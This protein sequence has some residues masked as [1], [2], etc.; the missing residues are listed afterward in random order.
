MFYQPSVST[1]ITRTTG[2]NGQPIETVEESPYAGASYNKLEPAAPAAIT[3]AIQE[4]RQSI[5]AALRQRF[6]LMD[7]KA[8]ASGRSREVATGSFLRATARYATATEHLIR[9]VL[10]FALEVSALIQGQPGKYRSLR[11]SVELRQHVFDPSPLQ[12]AS[13]LALQQAGVISRQTLQGRIGIADSDAEDARILKEAQPPE[14]A[15]TPAPAADNEPT[16]TN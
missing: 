2:P 16:T 9:E 10:E 4:A 3:A 14:P 6:V 15:P 1:K 8:T 11:A 5:Y 7:D 13:D 12:V